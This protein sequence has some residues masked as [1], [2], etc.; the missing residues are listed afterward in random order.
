MLLA[1]VLPSWSCVQVDT[2]LSCDRFRALS[3][4]V[5][6]YTYSVVYKTDNTAVR[7]RCADH[8]TPFYPQK[9]A[10]T[11]PTSDD[12]SVGIVYLLT[13]TTEVYSYS[14]NCTYIS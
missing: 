3:S 14:Y 11:S 4:L 2:Q 1:A 7:I 5:C 12:R 10:L 6:N 8:A 9:L 13:K